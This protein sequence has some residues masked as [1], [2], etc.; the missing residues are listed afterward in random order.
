MTATT[1]QKIWEM[2][3]ELAKTIV[4]IAHTE[5]LEE[6]AK[7]Y[8]SS[9]WIQSFRIGQA[10]YR[11]ALDQWG[12][13]ETAITAS[14]SGLCHD[15]VTAYRDTY[16]QP[17]S[18][19]SLPSFLDS[20]LPQKTGDNLVER[21]TACVWQCGEVNSKF[22]PNELIALKDATRYVNLSLERIMFSAQRYHGIPII[23][24]NNLLDDP[25]SS[26]EQ[27]RS[28]LWHVA[29]ALQWVNPESDMCI[30]TQLAQKEALFRA[31][32]LRRYLQLLRKQIAEE[33]MYPE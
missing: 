21:V 9:Q 14:L 8:D 13:K 25:K 5:T 23:N 10:A 30:R 28:V 19:K 12:D 3:P 32:D 18:G 7:I 20:I 17:L 6:L 26:F 27:P 4:D 16:N 31:N 22:D 15:V 29:L 33:K 1:E 2:Y 24:Y 11:F